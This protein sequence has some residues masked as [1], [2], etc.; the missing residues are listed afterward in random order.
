MSLVRVIQVRT[1]LRYATIFTRTMTAATM[2]M[3]VDRD[4]CSVETMIQKLETLVCANEYRRLVVS[5]SRKVA[6]LPQAGVLQRLMTVPVYAR[7]IIDR[8]HSLPR[9]LKRNCFSLSQVAGDKGTLYLPGNAPSENK[10]QRGKVS[11][12]KCHKSYC[13]RLYVT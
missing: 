7:G 9:I 2:K 12:V 1:L 6:S 13:A 8:F 11:V 4:E 3:Y 10:S 5:Q